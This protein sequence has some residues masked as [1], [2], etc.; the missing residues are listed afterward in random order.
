[1]AGENGKKRRYDREFKMSAYKKSGKSRIDLDDDDDW[2][3]EFRRNQK[4]GWSDDDD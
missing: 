4:R 1:M 2:E 3:I